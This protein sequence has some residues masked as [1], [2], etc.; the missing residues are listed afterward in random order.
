MLRARHAHP[1]HRHS[2]HFHSVHSGRLGRTR[3]LRLGRAGGIDLVGHSALRVLVPTRIVI[4]AG[5]KIFNRMDDDGE[6]F[7]TVLLWF[8]S[9]KTSHCR[10]RVSVRSVTALVDLRS[11]LTTNDRCHHYLAC[12][13]R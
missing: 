7:L 5:R 12:P 1:W 11:C 2:R 9:K 6:G 4:V 10:S 3:F 8:V 13:G